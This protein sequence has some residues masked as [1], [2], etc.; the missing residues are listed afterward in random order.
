MAA[1]QEEEVRPEYLLVNA[2]YDEAQPM[3]YILGEET[4]EEMVARFNSYCADS[5]TPN[6][7]QKEEF[8]IV[9][10]KIQEQFAILCKVAMMPEYDVLDEDIL[11]EL[12]LKQV[13]QVHDNTIGRLVHPLHDIRH[14]FVDE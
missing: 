11:H 9:W 6:P 2:A 13:V 14:K 8:Q 4:I 1:P 3:N 5:K 10:A 7:D 12:V